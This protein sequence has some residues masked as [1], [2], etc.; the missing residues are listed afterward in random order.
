MPF[1]RSDPGRGP[2]HT[3]IC[4]LL[5]ITHPVVLGGMGSLTGSVVAAIIVTILPELLRPLH[6][7]TGVDLRMVIYSASLI[8]LM[9]LRPQGLLG[10]KEWTDLWRKYVQRGA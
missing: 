9:I 7:L 5:G 3:R 4:D 8:L 6:E 1:H 2:L 10:S